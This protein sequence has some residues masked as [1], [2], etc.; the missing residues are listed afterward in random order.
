MRRVEASLPSITQNRRQYGEKKPRKKIF[1]VF[2]VENLV[3]SDV[4]TLKNFSRPERAF[5]KIYLAAPFQAGICQFDRT[6]SPST[7]NFCVRRGRFDE[8]KG[9]ERRPRLRSNALMLQ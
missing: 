5:E 2:F 1:F 3:F 4:K 9:G 7:R 6:A 8:K